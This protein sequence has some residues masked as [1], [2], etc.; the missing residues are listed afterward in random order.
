L[1]VNV[2][3]VIG[4]LSEDCGLGLVQGCTVRSI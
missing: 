1:Q 2:I 4:L 3:I